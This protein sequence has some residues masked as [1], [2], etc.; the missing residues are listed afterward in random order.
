MSDSSLA[1]DYE[2][3]SHSSS[4]SR[5]SSRENKKRRT[6][7]RSG[8]IRNDKPMW[9]KKKSSSSR[10]SSRSSA[11]SSRSRSSKPAARSPSPKLDDAVTLLDTGEHPP[12]VVGALLLED[13]RIT[14]LIVLL[15]EGAYQEVVPHPF[16]E[17][18]TAKVALLYLPEVERPE[19]DHR[20]EDVSDTLEVLNQ[21]EEEIEVVVTLQELNPHHE[22]TIG[23]R[24]QV[25]RLQKIGNSQKREE[26]KECGW[27]EGR[28]VL[29]YKQWD[30]RKF[31]DIRRVRRRYKKPIN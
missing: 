28:T 4:S 7:S 8:S 26:E 10:S 12:F 2:D 18:D 6:R 3:S 24:D 5:S 11:L 21:P 17:D 1:L 25:R 23:D 14:F 27:H 16:E 9:N 15:K 30:L 31:G 29:R 22:E 13:Q 20:P 19:V